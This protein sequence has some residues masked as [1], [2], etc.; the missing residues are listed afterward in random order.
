MEELKAREMKIKDQM[1]GVWISFKS[2]RALWVQC[3]LNKRIHIL[4]RDHEIIKS[5]YIY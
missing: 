2:I 1:K 3:L 5:L 4:I